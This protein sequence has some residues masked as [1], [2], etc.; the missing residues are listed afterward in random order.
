MLKY[1]LEEG[2]MESKNKL[3]LVELEGPDERRIKQR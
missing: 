2:E 3:F 1:M